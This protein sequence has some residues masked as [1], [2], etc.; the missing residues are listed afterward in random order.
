[1]RKTAIL[2][3]ALVALFTPGCATLQGGNLAQYNGF[4][5]ATVQYATLRTIDGD[6]D[7]ADR[8]RLVAMHAIEYAADDTRGPTDVLEKAVRARIDWS[9][10]SPEA[11]L[12]ADALIS[13]VRVELDRA[14]ADTRVSPDAKLSAIAVLEWVEQA[15]ALAAGPSA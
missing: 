6:Q 1:M 8:V 4:F 2:T 15:A 7:R 12:L 5:R 9:S 10:L 13:T 14:L 11:T 3:L